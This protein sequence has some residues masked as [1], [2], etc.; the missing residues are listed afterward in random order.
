M[1]CRRLLERHEDSLA[2][3]FHRRAQGRGQRRRELSPDARAARWVRVQRS[4]DSADWSWNRELCLVA[5]AAC[6]AA[7]A[8]RPLS[9]F[10]DDGSGAGERR[11][12]SQPRPESGAR[13]DGLLTVVAASLDAAVRGDGKSDLLL[14][15]AF[16]AS[17]PRAHAA[18]WPSLVAAAPLLR[19]AG[20]ELA[21]LDADAND[22]PP[23]HDAGARAPGLIMYAGGA[24]GTP[25]FVEDFADGRLTLM[26][27]LSFAA[28]TAGVRA[29][30]QAAEA[31]MSDDAMQM[32]LI[33]RPWEEEEEA[34]DAEP[35]WLASRRRRSDDAAEL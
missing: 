32:R 20:C 6:P 4:G 9:D 25:R 34:W 21:V 7:L 2:E 29:T 33:A 22:A 13:Q 12:R 24:K 27:V 31:A 17:A 1:E 10:A 15:V 28:H 3:A 5:S 19:A 8:S 30:A 14:Y 26:D 16:P 18:V 23:P 35:A 11:Y